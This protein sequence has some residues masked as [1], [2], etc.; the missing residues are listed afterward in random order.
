MTM[1]SDSV[2]IYMQNGHMY[3]RGDGIVPAV[4]CDFTKDVHGSIKY[5]HGTFRDIYSEIKSPICSI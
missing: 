5:S 1:I 3:N 2:S 4:I